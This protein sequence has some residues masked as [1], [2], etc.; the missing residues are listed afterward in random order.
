[1]FAERRKRLGVK[2]AGKICVLFFV[3]RFNK[4]VTLKMLIFF[5]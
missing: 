2:D 1:M 4:F 3:L 5:E